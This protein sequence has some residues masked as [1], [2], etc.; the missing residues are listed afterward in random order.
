MKIENEENKHQK[1]PRKPRVK[2]AFDDRANP[3]PGCGG[4]DSKANGKTSAG[5]L[6]R[7]CRLCLK[8]WT[9]NPLFKPGGSAGACPHC[10][11]LKTKLNSANRVQRGNCHA[12]KKSWK[13]EDSTSSNLKDYINSRIS[14]STD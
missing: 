3:C 9:L 13:I 6:K 1:K 10:G 12:C 7:R 5:S 8:S 14:D 2:R 11:S 4:M